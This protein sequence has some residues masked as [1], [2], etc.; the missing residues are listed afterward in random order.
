MRC[1]SGVT[2]AERRQ[3]SCAL[4]LQAGRIADAINSEKV[5][6]CAERRKQ[7]AT[8]A[9][10]PSLDVLVLWGHSAIEATFAVMAGRSFR[11]SD[12]AEM[13]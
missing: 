2:L 3:S 12:Q 11:W 5:K 1:D 13:C 4:K 8:V 10:M 6:H 9:P 7:N